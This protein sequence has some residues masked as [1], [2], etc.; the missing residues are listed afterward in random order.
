MGPRQ[1]SRG[2]LPVVSGPGAGGQG[3]AA[4]RSNSGG[5]RQGGLGG[6]GYLSDQESKGVRMLQQMSVEGVNLQ[7]Q[8]NNQSG[9][10][11]LIQLSPFQCRGGFFD[12]I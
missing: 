11:P 4:Q 2:Y 10:D 1:N 3:G 12:D 8:T 9:L 7:Q 6:S 5:R